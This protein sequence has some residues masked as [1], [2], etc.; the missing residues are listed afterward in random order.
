M[1]GD[2]VGGHEGVG[3]FVSILY[4]A[5]VS[6]L[7]FLR[8]VSCRLIRYQCPQLIPA[9]SL[10]N[11]SKLCGFTRPR[12]VT[13]MESAYSSSNSAGGLPLCRNAA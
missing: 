10:A 11:Y 4:I 1:P 8:V 12:S 7:L 5:S 6:A 9:T 2:V 3:L 13:L